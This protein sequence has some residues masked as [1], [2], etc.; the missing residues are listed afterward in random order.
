MAVEIHEDQPLPAPAVAPTR[1]LSAQFVVQLNYGAGTWWHPARLDNG[2]KVWASFRVPHD[3]NSFV[4]VEIVLWPG[5]TVVHNVTT[6]YYAS[7]GGE[8]YNNHTQTTVTA[9]NVVL[10]TTYIMDALA[11][12]P[13]F[14][15]ALTPGDNVMIRMGSPVIRLLL[16]ETVC[17]RYI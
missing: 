6:D 17:V 2:G 14:W 4:S 3:F 11:D 15:A 16:A 12:A 9:P 7:Q 13:A 5:F 8:A 1:E 10:N